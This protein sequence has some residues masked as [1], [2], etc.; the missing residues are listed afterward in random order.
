[1]RKNNTKIIQ[2]AGFRGLFM[3]LFIGICLAAGFVV[4]PAKVAVYAWN[5]LALNY[6]SIP[7]INLFQGVLLWAII[8][9][10][11]YM[12]NNNRMVISFAQPK[13]LSEEEMKR[14]MERIRLQAQARQLNTMVLKSEELKTLAHKQEME[15]TADSEVSKNT[16]SKNL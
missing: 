10:V 16:D 11:C 7:S 9:M 15:K 12:A 13:Q 1:M 8:V 14:L 5:Y 4:F 3:A 2:I 6:L